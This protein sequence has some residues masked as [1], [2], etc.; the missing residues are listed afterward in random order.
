MFSP[1]YSDCQQQQRKQKQ[2][3]V[4]NA[5]QS[6]SLSSSPS[7]NRCSARSNIV[8]IKAHKCASSAIQN[9]FMRYGYF[10]NKIFVLPDKGNYL[11]HPSLFDRNLV[12]NPKLFKSEYN[13]LTHHS[14]LNYNE[15]R[16]LMPN[17]TVYLTIVR[18]PVH[19]FESMFHYYRLNKLWGMNFSDFNHRDVRLPKK[20]IETRLIGKIGVNQMM[21]DMGLSQND[22]NDIEKIKKYIAKLDSIFSLVLVAERMEESLILLKHLL[23][24]NYD[25]VVV[26][27][28]NAR[29]EKTKHPVNKIGDKRIR[30]L[31][32]ADQMLY[33][34]FSQKFDEKVQKF[35]RKRMAKEIEKLRD[36]IGIFYEFCVNKAFASEQ[37]NNIIR[38]VTQRENNLLCQFLTH[39]ELSL[40][41]FIRTQQIKRFPLSV[42]QNS[43]N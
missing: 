10:N 12:P 35:G 36:R 29:D 38:F 14:R 30:E 3:N 41:K 21:F 18:D 15:M 11:G 1:F 20:I 32:R 25:D 28:V 19:L 9:I 43:T 17:D 42:F 4:L 26:F 37:S 13:I 6:S 34:Y 23:C 5:S 33:E 8:F 16:R 27:K 2:S 24:W 39:S 7:P 40:T 22:F 31:N